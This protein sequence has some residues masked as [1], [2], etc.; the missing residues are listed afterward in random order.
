M[1]GLKHLKLLNGL[2]C[3]TLL[4]Y[5]VA[6]IAPITATA[7]SNPAPA[8]G[9]QMS[10]IDAY[11]ETQMQELRI[12]GLALGIVQGDQIVHLQGFGIADPS[13]RTVTAQTPFNIG[14]TTKSFT[15]LAIMQLVEAG[16]IDL[17][18]P[19]QRY[20]P[21]FRVT[22][23]TASTQITV[24]HL[25]NQ[26]SGFSTRIGRRVPDANLDLREDGLEQLVRDLSN[27]TLSQPVGQGF[28][29]SNLNYWTLGLIVQTVAGQSYEEYI[30]Q[31]IFTPL[32]MPHAYT[33]KADASDL[34]IG[35]RYWFGWPVAAE[36]PDNRA[37]RPAGHLMASAEDLAHYLIAQVND[38]RYANGSI[39]SPAGIA[40]M[41][42]PDT[43]AAQDAGY[44][45][46]WF[47]GTIN[48]VP[49]VWHDG[50]NPTFHAN[51]ILIPNQ[52]WGIVLLENAN[53]LPQD[54]PLSA[55]A[56]GVASLLVGRQPQ[57]VTTAPFLVALYGVALGLTVLAPVGMVWSL[58]TWRRWSAR[59]VQAPGWRGQLV[60]VMLPLL[61]NLLL[62]LILLVGLPWLF[63]APLFGLTYVFS[64]LGYT[65]L[66][67]GVVALGWGIV[68]TVAYLALH[69]EHSFSILVDDHDCC[70][71]Y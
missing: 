24:R 2:T 67:G 33:A 60:H 5:L 62:A 19:V 23:T 63:K 17:D 70:D 46:G 53:S 49:M 1:N 22:D 44:G 13:G 12:P 9:E 7:Q 39:L 50:G 27:T 8:D 71:L 65:L 51:L 21:W 14:S 28:Q 37:E 68:R 45:M 32:A 30:Q 55:I 47:S 6:L 58:I 64:D 56:N 41:H 69:V 57:V 48:G 42:R 18:A 20:L 26:T 35:Y 40:E 52:R 10:A 36:L 38:G 3:L 61:L 54:G 34:A 16:Q 66:V 11:I 25:L 29:Y 15:A 4:I 43:S 59:L 31:H